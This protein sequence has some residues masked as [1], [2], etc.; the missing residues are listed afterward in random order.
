[1][2]D[3]SRTW[4]WEFEDKLLNGSLIKEFESCL[5][6]GKCV[7]S[8]P[9]ATVSRHYNV[10]KI[11]RDMMYGK[12]EELLRSQEIWDC[13]LCNNCEVLCPQDEKIPNLIHVLRHEALSK[14][15]GYDLIVELI[16]LAE[17]FL[18]TGSIMRNKGTHSFREALGMEPERKISSKTIEDMN[19]LCQKTGFSQ[20]IKQ[21]KDRKNEAG[22]RKHVY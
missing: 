3:A 14:G 18:R 16:P 13:F 7:G 15:Y 4:T 1:M 21:I 8:C 19:K 22:K 6:C 2:V 12:A 20:L 10:R 5:Q 9:A 11:I 17:M